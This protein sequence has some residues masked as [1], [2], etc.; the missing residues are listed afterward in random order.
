MNRI[1]AI[2]AEHRDWTPDERRPTEELVEKVAMQ[3]FCDACFVIS[4][5]FCTVSFNLLLRRP[6]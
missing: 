6:H 3:R 4:E 1:G 5:S 2:K